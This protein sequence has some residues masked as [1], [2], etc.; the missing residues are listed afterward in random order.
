MTTRDKLVLLGSFLV[1]S[2]LGGALVY[3]HWS[4]VHL[5]LAAATRSG[6]F[7]ALMALVHWVAFRVHQIQPQNACRLDNSMASEGSPPSASSLFSHLASN[8]GPAIKF[9]V[10][11]Q[12]TF[13]ILGALTLDGGYLGRACCVTAI[14]H[15]TAILLIVVRRPT[16]PKT[17]DLLVV[18]YGFLFIGPF[19]FW[20]A[21]FVQKWAG[22]GV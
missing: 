13:L 18:H 9:A 12:V 22:T 21:P 4:G 20:L 3:S 11:L 19:V 17:L 7:V 8:Y 5:P 1:T 16:L 10:I 15:W 2:A 6:A 14:A